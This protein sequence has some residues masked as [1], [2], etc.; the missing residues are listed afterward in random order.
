M[1]KLECPRL[2]LKYGSTPAWNVLIVHVALPT[3]KMDA[4]ENGIHCCVPLSMQMVCMLATA[5]TLIMCFPC[6]HM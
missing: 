6:N 5:N 3:H 4:L 1:W 2:V